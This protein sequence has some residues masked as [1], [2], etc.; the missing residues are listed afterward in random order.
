MKIPKLL[1][2]SLINWCISMFFFLIRI[3][4]WK[5]F[6]IFI[7][8]MFWN[9]SLFTEITSIRQIKQCQ[10]VTK[11]NS[12]K[13]YGEWFC[14]Y[15]IILS[16]FFLYFQDESIKRLM[17]YIWFFLKCFIPCL[18]YFLLWEQG[19]WIRRK[20]IIMNLHVIFI[21]WFNVIIQVRF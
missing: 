7:Y 3:K 14:R 1:L 18:E 8:N 15:K 16:H 9:V 13:S 5:I 12:R 19:I 4:L 11:L 2:T 10:K 20:F 17:Q 6:H 21:F